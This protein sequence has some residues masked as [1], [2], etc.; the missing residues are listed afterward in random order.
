MSGILF[1]TG[2]RGFI[3]KALVSRLLAT[4]LW[5]IRVLVRRPVVGDNPASRLVVGDLCD[6]ET[7]R[8]S[9]EGVDTVIHLAALTGKAAPCDYERTNVEGTKILL[10]ACK[11]VGVRRFLHVSTIAA[12]YPDQRYYPYAQSKARAEALVQAGGIPYIIV[13]PTV[14]IGE[15]SPIWKTLRRVAKLPLI[16]LPNG[17]RVRLQPIHVDD[18][19]AGIELTLSEARFEGETLDLG[20]P[21]CISLAD[22]VA[23]AHRAFCG[24]APRFLSVPLWPIRAPLALVEPLLRAT[25]PITAGQLAL[26]ANDSAASPNWVHDRLVKTMRT[27]EKMIVTLVSKEPPSRLG[28]QQPSS[29]SGIGADVLVLRREC[30]TFTHYLVSRSPTDYIRNQYEAAVLARDL[31]DDETFS[32]FDRRTI[33]LARRDGFWVRAADA[34]CSIFYRHG[35]LRRK[36]T[37]LLAI[38]EH[39]APTAAHFDRPKIRAPAGLGANLLLTGAIFGVSLIAGMLMLLPPH[40]LAQKRFGCNFEGS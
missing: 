4:G 34:Y 14:V 13:R 9:L 30:E 17:G 16:P 8:S 15:G 31:A 33:R 29:G 35:V 12:A 10:Q 26:F 37:L 19:V 32:A 20:G 24:K 5:Q 18:V 40:L 27:P 39:T 21:D 36:L 25:L 3:G 38:L 23:A 28:G 2:S 7:Y 11:D 22:F 1:I 6:A